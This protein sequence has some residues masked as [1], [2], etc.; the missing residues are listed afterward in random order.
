VG[1][2]KKFGGHQLGFRDKMVEN[3]PNFEKFTHVAQHGLQ[4]F[5]VKNI[6]GGEQS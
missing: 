2:A 6:D 5:I 1:N 3:C 4:R